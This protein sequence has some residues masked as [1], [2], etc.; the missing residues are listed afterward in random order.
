MN[1]KCGFILSILT[2]MIF[3]LSS[4]AQTWTQVG[5][6]INGEA[7]G[8]QIE[9][10]N[11]VSLS[12]D[13]SIMA[14]GAVWNNGN[15]SNAGHVR[16]YENISG[17]WTKIGSDIDGEGS[18]DLSGSSV[19]LSSDGSNV[20]IGA[21]GNDGNSFYSGHVRIYK[22][23]RDTW[24]QVGSDIDGEAAG[25]WSGN[26]VSLSSD[27]STVAIGAYNNGG[28]GFY[29]GHIR[30]YKNISGTWTQVG[31]DIDGEAADD[32]SGWS[33]SLS[34]DGS[35]VAI[36]A[37]GNDGNGLDAGHV[38][39]Y[40]NISS[41]WT[42]VGSDI[43]GAAAGDWSG[44]SVSLS[45]DG[46]TVAIGA[47]NNG[48]NGLDAGHVRIYKNIRDTWTQVG[49]DIDGEAADDRSGCSVSLS[50]DG[51][52]VAIGATLNDGNGSNAGHVRMYKNI[53]GTWTKVGS[54]IDGE[55]AG[56][57]SGFVSLSSDGSTVA[58]GASGNDGNGSSSGHVRVYSLNGTSS[59]LNTLNGVSIKLFPNPTSGTLHIQTSPELIGESY[60][61]FA[62]SGS[63]KL[64][65]EI[66]SID[67]Q[68]DLKDF[69]EGVYLI[70]VG[71][72]MQRSF[73]VMKK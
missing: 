8:D 49:A 58:I 48:G 27:G 70:N 25:D 56:D 23:I 68:L 45:S 67:M 2:L 53:S 26:S 39:I 5:S 52:T 65:G 54:D 42:Q 15:G 43:D 19:S 63:K 36:G 13:G 7:A 14:I 1:L 22:N 44:N 59:I 40:K 73:K 30:I 72:K 55:A 41:T 9:G 31:S 60:Q 64:Q 69:A 61:V 20:A 24:T 66:I 32:R 71:D 62:I 6:D 17:T 33:V 46:S 16:I 51:S 28:N 18:G 3:N 21:C 38:R 57:G 50:S 11:P 47:Y 37:S 29:S 35:T 12:S 10:I 34:S 4:L